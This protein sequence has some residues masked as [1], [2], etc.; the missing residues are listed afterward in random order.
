MKISDGFRERVN[1]YLGFEFLEL[2]EVGMEL[3]RRDDRGIHVHD[4][5]YS[6]DLDQQGHITR[7][8]R[9]HRE[10]IAKVPKEKAE[11]I[12]AA[13]FPDHVPDA[14]FWEEHASEVENLRR[15]F[16]APIQYRWINHVIHMETAEPFY[17][18]DT[19][20]PYHATY[21]HYW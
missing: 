8:N 6:K 10:N 17:A 20:P 14:H 1:L 3:S 5:N 4:H 13:L 2:N 11:A 21:V 9:E 7:Q 19:I 16:H 15:S 12:I 18:E